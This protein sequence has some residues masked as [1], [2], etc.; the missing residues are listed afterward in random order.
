MSNSVKIINRSAKPA[1]IGFFKNRGPYQPSFD[2]EKV[3]EVGPHESQSVILENGWE[4]RIQKLSGAANDPATWAE[5][6][7]N[8][9]QNMTFADISLIRGYNGSMVFTSSDGTLHTGIANDLWAEAPAKFKI[10]DSYGNDVLVPTEPYTGGRNDELIAYYRRKVT[11]GNGY[12]IPDDHASSHGTH[13]A[14]INLEIY[15]DNSAISGTVNTIITSKVIALRSNANG[16]FVCAENAGNSP[17]VA[18]RDCA[19]GW[20]TFDLII[21]NENNVALKSHANGQYVCAENGGNSPL[22][23]NRASI[24]SWETFQMIDRGNGKVAFIAVNGNYVCA[25]D[26]GN[27]A[28]IANRNS[29]DNWETFDLVST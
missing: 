10:K 15:D 3:I 18:N 16:K 24:S 19:S 23:A 20:E 6:H 2:A 26:F 22:I 27:G 9:W 14:N 13:D 7:F 12:L 25:E 5:I 21:L 28:L 17:L 4:G 11:K 8:A 29:V 1:K